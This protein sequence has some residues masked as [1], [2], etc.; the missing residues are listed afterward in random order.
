[1]QGKYKINVWEYVKVCKK[2]INISV[3]VIFMF[4]YGEVYFEFRSVRTKLIQAFYF[5]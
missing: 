3:T 5:A 4:T 1:M 2:Y